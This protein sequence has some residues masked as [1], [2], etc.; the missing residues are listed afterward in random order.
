VPLLSS[1]S[2]VLNRRPFTQRRL[3]AGCL[4]RPFLPLRVRVLS[5]RRGASAAVG[6][7]LLP[8]LF[9]A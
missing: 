3:L 5:C 9:G 6:A 2:S 4:A 7:A 1:C 8:L